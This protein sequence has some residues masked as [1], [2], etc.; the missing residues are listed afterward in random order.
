MQNSVEITTDR[1]FFSNMTG[2]QLYIFTRKK[3]LHIRFPGNF[4]NIFRAFFYRTYTGDKKL[5]YGFINWIHY[6]W[7]F[8]IIISFYLSVLQYLLFWILVLDFFEQQPAWQQFLVGGQQPHFVECAD[9]KSNW[10]I[11]FNSSVSSDIFALISFL[12]L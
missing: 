11:W 12:L 3:L 1:T 5:N 6:F 7:V 10:R 4:T 8:N 2:Q 9:L